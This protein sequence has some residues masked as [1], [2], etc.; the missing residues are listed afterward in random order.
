[1][2]ELLKDLSTNF[3]NEDNYLRQ[4]IVN[5][6]SPVLVGNMFQFQENKLVSIWYSQMR[7]TILNINEKR[8]KLSFT[9]ITPVNKG[10]TQM[11]LFSEQ[12]QKLTLATVEKYLKTADFERETI[13]EEL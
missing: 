6:H 11:G 10:T 12:E 1:M 7:T 5:S 2:A 13:L 8:M 3:A 4:V 9:K